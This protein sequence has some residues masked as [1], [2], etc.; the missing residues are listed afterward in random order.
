MKIT[1]T[2]SQ[3]LRFS[4]PASPFLPC[5][6]SANSLDE[7]ADDAMIDD[8]VADLSSEVAAFVSFVCI[9]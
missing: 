1:K 4:S 7:Q 3:F 6:P 9:S 8:D 2:F 5:C